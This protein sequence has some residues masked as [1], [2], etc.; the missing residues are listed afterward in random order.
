MSEAGPRDLGE[1]A[2]HQQAMFETELQTFET[3]L[4]QLIETNLGEWALIK[5]TEL[6]GVYPGQMEAINAGYEKY[7]SQTLFLTRQILEQQPIDFYGY[8][9]AA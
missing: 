3:L 9:E 6:G 5:E 2:A 7:G 8:A 4:P 1:L